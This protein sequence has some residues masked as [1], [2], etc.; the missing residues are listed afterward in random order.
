MKDGGY[1]FPLV[2][3]TGYQSVEHGMTLREWYAGMALQGYLASAAKGV[4]PPKRVSRMA[5]R[6][7]DSMLKERER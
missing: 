6:Y 5:Y 1:A 7:A 4:R 2:V 3:P